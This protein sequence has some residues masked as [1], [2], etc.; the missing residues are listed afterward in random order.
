VEWGYGGNLKLKWAGSK[1]RSGSPSETEKS[2]GRERGRKGK[3]KMGPVKKL[4]IEMV[5]SAESQLVW[6]AGQRVCEAMRQGFGACQKT[7]LSEDGLA[8]S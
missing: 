5:K 2:A 3:A 6:K 8:F 7:S 4:W 1:S